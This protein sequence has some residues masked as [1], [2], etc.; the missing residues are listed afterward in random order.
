[1]KKLSF[2]CMLLGALLIAMPVS[3][4]KFN[5]KKAAKA[6]AKDLKKKKYEIF[7]SSLTLEMAI[8]Q[9]FEQQYEG[10]R[11]RIEKF[12][13]AQSTSK[14]IAQ[15]KAF[16]NAAHNYA[17]ECYANI[18]SVMKNTVNS[19]VLNQMADE[20]EKFEAMFVGEVEKEIAGEMTNTYNVIRTVDVQTT[21]GMKKGF[22]VERYYIIDAERARLIQERALKNAAGDGPLK[23]SISSIANYIE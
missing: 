6:K 19:N 22:E 4:G 9:H 12:G 18:S 10:G 16:A 20:M 2:F 23:E 14:S 13:T 3:A 7:G 5:A 1:M 15:Q 17:Q 21:S 11:K 8:Q